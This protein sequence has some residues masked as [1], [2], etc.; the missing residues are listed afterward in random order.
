MFFQR[1]IGFVRLYACIYFIDD[2]KNSIHMDRDCSYHLL[3][4]VL[5]DFKI[6]F[7][8]FNEYILVVL[9]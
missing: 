4:T 7:R 8:S 6:F 3:E 5:K 9:L 2:R 1:R